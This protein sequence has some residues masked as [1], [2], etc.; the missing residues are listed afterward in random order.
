MS[1]LLTA[2]LWLGLVSCLF[3]IVTVCV[4]YARAVRRE[5][6]DREQEE[7]SLFSGGRLR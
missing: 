2:A 4:C 6:E 1:T 3:S 5:D 7:Q